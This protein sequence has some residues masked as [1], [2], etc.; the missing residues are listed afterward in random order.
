MI[1]WVPASSEAFPGELVAVLFSPNQFYINGIGIYQET[2]MPQIT[3][4]LDDV[5]FDAV[6][7]TLVDKRDLAIASEAT[8]GR[9]VIHSIG[10]ALETVILSGRYMST[11]VKESI[12]GLFEQCRLT[13]A[14]VAFN[15]G[16]VDR[17]VL[18]RS[19]ETVPLIGA[20]EGY[21]FKIEL[22]IVG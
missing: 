9:A 4:S 8:I 1:L 15:D 11:S 16:D 14:K 22:V 20:T 13:G 6:P 17:D 12:V 7:E 3:Y 5:D 18:I 19:F 2:S 10:A 21:S